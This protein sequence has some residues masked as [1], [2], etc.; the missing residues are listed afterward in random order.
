M[1]APH[2]QERIFIM[3]KIKLNLHDLLVDALGGETTHIPA[4]VEI[5]ELLDFNDVHDGEL[6]LDDLLYENR[7]IAHVWSTEDVRSVR[8]DLD[9]D[10]AWKV[11]QYLDRHV[12]SER[13][14]TW[15]RVE[16]VAY[17]MFGSGSLKRVE[18]CDQLLRDYSDDLRESNLI[19]L[20]AD[21]MHW[22][23]AKGEDFDKSLELARTHHVAEV[24]S[25]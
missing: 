24:P 17:D 7:L 14:I 1:P 3:T 18:R 6:D 11:L 4:T 22:C 19:D 21:A 16:Q 8:A 23:Q 10:Q 15:E 13:G 25:K 12:D 9:D 2:P 5:S 20:L